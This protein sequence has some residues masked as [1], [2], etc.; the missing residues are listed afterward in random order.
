[1]DDEIITKNGIHCYEK[2]HIPAGEICLRKGEASWE[3]LI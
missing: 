1:M 3:T 2:Y